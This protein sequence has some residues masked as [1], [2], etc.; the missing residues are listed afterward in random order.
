MANYKLNKKQESQVADK[1]DDM[2]KNI[3]LSEAH[4]EVGRF[5]DELEYLD[6]CF[7]ISKDPKFS[8]EQLDKIEAHNVLV[9]YNLDQICQAQKANIFKY[10]SI[11]QCVDIFINQKLTKDDLNF[12][13]TTEFGKDY[14]AYSQL[15]E[16]AQTFRKVRDEELAKIKGK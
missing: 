15:Y 1:L 13:Q 4:K 6:S 5:Q 3:S 12:E 2:L 9:S 16:I 14:I 10:I 11:Q 8:K 7:F